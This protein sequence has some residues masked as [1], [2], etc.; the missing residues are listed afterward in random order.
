MPVRKQCEP[1]RGEPARAPAADA[2]IQAPGLLEL[3]PAASNGRLSGS[4][5][6]GRA[7]CHRTQ[8]RSSRTLWQAA[9]RTWPVHASVVLL[10][11]AILT[12]QVR[13]LE[14]TAGTALLRTGPDGRLTLTAYGQLFAHDLRPA[15]ESLAQS[16]SQAISHA[17]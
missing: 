14:T 1:A 13:Q 17:T 12:S 8:S 7:G 5:G 10:R 11:N 4:A 15:L 3:Q 6:A 9:P 16:L 2:R